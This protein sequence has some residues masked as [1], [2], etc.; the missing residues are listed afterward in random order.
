MCSN[1]TYGARCTIEKHALNIYFNYTKILRINPDHQFFFVVPRECIY[2]YLLENKAFG[3]E[4]SDC[5]IFV[6]S[7][8]FIYNNSSD[9]CLYLIKI[10][11]HF[12]FFQLLENM[13]SPK[14]SNSKQHWLFWRIK[15]MKLK[16][17]LFFVVVAL[18]NINP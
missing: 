10:V 16:M 2:C 8:A 6:Q 5:H 4:F 13:H 9:K 14:M 17:F 18:V 15:Y 1:S 11:F 12:Y 3:F 7:T